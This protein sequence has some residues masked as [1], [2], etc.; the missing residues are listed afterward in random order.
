MPV[1]YLNLSSESPPF[2]RKCKRLSAEGGRGKLV[3]ARVEKH[4][5]RVK[6]LLFTWRPTLRRS[7]E[8]RHDSS[9]R[10]GICTCAHRGGTNG[11]ELRTPPPSIT[12]GERGYGF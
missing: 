12:H 6:F 1:P 11:D 2:I 8:A 3:T 5:H 7:S 9:E 10:Y 4:V